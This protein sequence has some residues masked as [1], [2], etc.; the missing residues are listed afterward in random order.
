MEASVDGEIGGAAAFLQLSG[1]G[2]RFGDFDAVKAVD[3][4]VAE[5]EFLTLLGPSGCGKS[6]LLRMVGGFE[7]PSRGQVL[8]RGQDLTRAVPEARPFNMVFQSYALFPHMTVAENV[9]YGPRIAGRGN[10]DIRR[11]VE[12]VLELVHLRDFARRSVSELSGGQQQRVALARALVNE[13]EVLLLDEPLGALDLQLRRWLQEELR[14]IQRRLG[15]TFIY[16]T[17]DQEEALTLSHR[18]AVMERG[19]LAQVSDIREIYERPATK[20][21]AEFVGSTNL[22]DCTVVEERSERAGVR[23]ANG[24]ACELAHHGSRPFDREEQALAVLRPHHLELG[25]PESSAFAGTVSESLYLGTHTR[26]DIVLD[27]GTSIHVDADPGSYLAAGERVGVQVK[28]G[29]G[30]VVR[31]EGSDPVEPDERAED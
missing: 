2:K 7:L 27:D 14:S 15:T 5:G 4:D 24:F 11:R 10:D 29:S 22:I 31:D 19:E 6:T 1:L 30:A 25:A 13:P 20:F 12:D 23:F 16:V 26:H 17:H 18:I 3:L 28:G 9:G 8:L 21:V